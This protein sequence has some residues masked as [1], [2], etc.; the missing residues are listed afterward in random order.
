V[1]LPRGDNIVDEEFVRY[2]DFI[3]EICELREGTVAVGRLGARAR[4]LFGAQNPRAD[5]H[6]GF[7]FDAFDTCAGEAHLKSTFDG[8]LSTSLPGSES[9]DWRKVAI[10]G[11]TSTHLF[12][13]CCHQFDSQGAGN[14][15]F[16]LQQSLLLY[17]VL[18]HLIGG[19]EEF[20]RRLR[21][22]RN[23]IAA[24]EDEVRR[25]NM[26]ALLKDVETVITDGDLDAVSRFS[27]NQVEDE[28]IKQQFLDANADLTAALFRL[29]D[30]PFLRGTLSSFEMEAGT[31]RQRAEAFE[32]AFAEPATWQLLTGALLATGD[33]QRRRPNSTAWQFGTG[34]TTSEAVWRYL[35][36]DAPRASLALTRTV[37]GEL[38]D[39]VAASGMTVEDH[40]LAVTWAW[41][42]ERETSRN[43]DWRYY[44]VKYPS[45]REG[46]TGIYFGVDAKLGYSMCMLRTKQ[47]N[48]KYRDPI[49]LELW[50]SS[51]AG[52]K[53]EDPWFT[54][55][56]TLPR[57]LRLGRSGVGIQSLAQ[58]FGLE[59]PEDE[60]LASAFDAICG[61]RDVVVA[62]GDGF[63]LG[64]HQEDRGDGPVDAADRVAVGAALLRDLIEAGL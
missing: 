58:G 6:L 20:G 63:L 30:H 19:T 15:A 31:F 39:G 54:G 14:R 61:Q 55:Y 17:A 47:L 8:H 64:I 13:Q 2:L 51:G 3:T 23:L 5:E 29:E 43:L 49:L 22:L 59:R 56:D 40:L 52:D 32:A 28:R 27:S 25:P 36:T 26:P 46:A 44:L 21:V 60:Q 16:T 53:V 34:S 10:F 38:L 50:R 57:W 33:Y 1:A 35:L 42:A 48:G 41:L 9:Y 12:E 62:E 37:L 11:A 4:A 24:S 18:L 45:M 7:L